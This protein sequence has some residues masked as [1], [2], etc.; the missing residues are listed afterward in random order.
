MVRAK[1]SGSPKRNSIIAVAVVVVFGVAVLGYIL[2]PRTDTGMVMAGGNQSSRET[3]AET[4]QTVTISAIQTSQNGPPVVFLPQNFTVTEGKPVVL[5]FVN[6]DDSSHELTIPA[7]NITTGIVQAS[8]TLRMIFTPSE[9]GTFQ[10]GQPGG[11]GLDVLGN[12]T[13]LPP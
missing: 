1:G 6:N 4:R 7:L 3:S 2:L 10:F 5:V 13:V 12:M 8:T 11:R 9:T